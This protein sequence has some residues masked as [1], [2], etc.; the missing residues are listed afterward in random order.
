MA[1][2]TTVAL[3]DDLDGSEATT[4]VSFTLDGVNYEI[5]LNDQHA[6]ELR[7]QFGSWTTAARRVGGR[8]KR[9]TAGSAVDGEAAK[10]RQWAQ[11][12]GVEVSERGRIAASVRE[13][14]A[15]AH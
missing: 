15:A 13:A 5:D 9:H 3:I 6:E 4:T 14:Y 10:I 11:E 8:A 1:R 2:K 12:N 7:D